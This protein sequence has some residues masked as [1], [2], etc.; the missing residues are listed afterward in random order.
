MGFLS[1]SVSINRY[2]VNGT[3]EKPVVETVERCLKSNT[4]SNI[5]AGVS[6]KI[7]GWTSFENP[8]KPDF[9]GGSFVYGPYFAFS[10][11]ID[12]KVLPP[13]IIQ[14][15]IALET[16]KR[17]SKSG[18]EDLTAH[19]KSMLKD[20]VLNI[21]NLRIPSTPN[22]FDIVWNHEKSSLWFFSNLKTANEELETLFMKSFNLTVTRLFPFTTAELV[23]ELSDVQKDVLLKLTPTSFTD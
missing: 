10:L 14:K 8:F 9:Q 19:E 13:K 17:L 6:Q 15:Y 7:S 4:I 21:L 23:V 1:S 5:D 12:K 22:L 2:R 3:L 18:R 20:H 16:E 11:R